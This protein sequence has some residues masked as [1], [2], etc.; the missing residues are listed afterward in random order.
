MAK[1]V[2]STGSLTFGASATNVAATSSQFMALKGGASTQI[3]DFLE[4]LITGMAAASTVAGMML[5][6]SS[7]LGITPTAL[8]SPGQDGPM[9][10]S[11]T[12]LSSTVVAYFAAATGP[13]PTNSVTLPKLNLG[14]N[15]FGGIL[16]WNA[17]PTQQWTQVG[18]STNGGES[19]L[20]NSSTAGGASGLANAHIMY[21]PT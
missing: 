19:V 15:L 11:A 18:N 8:A 17:A 13:V 6:F 10:A 20:W 16:R 7:T 14:L 9:N 1:R 2:F 4:V 12:A 21:E 5:A 3:V